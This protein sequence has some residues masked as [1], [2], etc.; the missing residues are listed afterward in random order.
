MYSSKSVKSLSLVERV[1]KIK[2]L[3]QN[4]HSLKKTPVNFDAADTSNSNLVNG[5]LD[6][7]NL[8]LSIA[9]LPN[10]IATTEI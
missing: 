6:L 10:L 7:K 8:T 4:Y 2:K 1:D 5:V 9:F 3:Q